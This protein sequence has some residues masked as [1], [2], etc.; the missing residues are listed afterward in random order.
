MVG[1]GKYKVRPLKTEGTDLKKILKVNLSARALAIYGL[2]PDDWCQLSSATGSS[3]LVQVWPAAPNAQDTWIQITD[4]LRA[5]HHLNLGDEVHLSRCPQTRLPNAKDVIVSE[6]QNRAQ[7]GLQQEERRHWVW[8]LD[9]ELEQAG[10]LC[11]GMIFNIRARGE[12]RAFRIKSINLS[13]RMVPYQYARHPKVTIALEENHTSNGSNDDAAARPA[14][15]EAAVLGGLDAQV[16]QLNSVV[17]N[18]SP[19]ADLFKAKSKHRQRRGGVILHGPPGTGKSQ[20]LQM[21]S[22]LALWSKIYHMDDIMDSA[23]KGG[24]DA[25]IRQMFEDACRCQP[26]VIIIDKLDVLARKTEPTYDSQSSS[27]V[28]NLCKGLD[29]RDNN[30]VFVV[31][32][33]RNLALVDESLR[34]PGRFEIEIEIP[35]P[36]TAARAQILNLAFGSPRDSMDEQLLE[37]ADSTHGYVG[38]DLKQLLDTAMDQVASRLQASSNNKQHNATDNLNTEDST[39]TELF[40]KNDIETALLQ[41]KPT[42]MR[43]IFLDT[44]RVKWADIGGQ[45]ELKKALRKAIEWPLKVSDPNHRLEGSVLSSKVSVDHGRTSSSS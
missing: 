15:V 12:E 23:S 42:A 25:A 16:S 24:K 27:I 39:F 31:S 28:T 8:L 2:K 26:S 18:Y 37:L 22:E 19:S 14:N 10:T 1:A 29:A 4:D 7:E 40:T 6:C 45:D 3:F 13:D 32:A 30:R 41:V 17:A 35:V 5:R 11:P 20:V 38:S 44:P 43:E 36:G 9:H 34:H 33:A 21:V